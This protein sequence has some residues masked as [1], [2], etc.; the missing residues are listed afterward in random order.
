MPFG[1]WVKYLGVEKIPGIL[2]YLAGSEISGRR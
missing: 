2:K 1:D